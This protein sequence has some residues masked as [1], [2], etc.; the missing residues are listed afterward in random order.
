MWI[1]ARRAAGFAVVVAL[2]CW[3]S[4]SL[5]SPTITEYLA[6]TANRQPLWITSGPSDDLWFGSVSLG[7]LSFSTV[8]GQITE[9]SAGLS[10]APLGVTSGPDGNVWLTEAGV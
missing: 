1:F 3:A 6:P 7:D 5:G 8:A 10:G 2:L 9:F 4:P